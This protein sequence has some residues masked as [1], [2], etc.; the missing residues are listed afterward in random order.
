MKM[1]AGR[2]FYWIFYFTFSLQTFLTGEILINLI[3]IL[4]HFFNLEI[5]GFLEPF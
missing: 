1:D 2:N 4:I 5:I 3:S